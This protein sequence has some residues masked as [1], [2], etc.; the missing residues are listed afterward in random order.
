[1]TLLVQQNLLI[2]LSVLVLGKEFRALLGK[3]CLLS[4]NKL[5]P[6]PVHACMKET[7]APPLAFLFPFPQYP[8][9]FLSH[10]FLHLPLPSP[11]YPCSLFLL[12]AP[13]LL[14]LTLYRVSLCS[15]A[16]LKCS[17]LPGL[18]EKLHGRMPTLTFPSL[19][20]AYGSPHGIL[21]SKDHL[22]LAHH[23]FSA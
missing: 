21:N 8:P 6:S 1:M 11:L 18:Q 7:I 14:S 10:L 5:H 2:L 16:G 17:F 13:F 23:F 9:S 4:T 12:P 22:L 19:L 15:Q 3:P 20:R